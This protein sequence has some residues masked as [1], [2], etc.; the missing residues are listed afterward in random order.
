MFAEHIL[1]EVETPGKI[2]DAWYPAIS[3]RRYAIYLCHLVETFW[4]RQHLFIDVDLI[5]TS[6]VE[7][8]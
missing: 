2:H 4:R 1:R 3:R 8:T 5:G 6:D 7:M